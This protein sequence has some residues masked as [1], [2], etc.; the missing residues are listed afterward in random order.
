MP[1][2]CALLPDRTIHRIFNGWY[3]V[4][5]PTAEELRLAMREM[6]GSS[7]GDLDF[8]GE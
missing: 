4:G 3:F 8:R 2:T 5:R 1:F 7:V 6:I